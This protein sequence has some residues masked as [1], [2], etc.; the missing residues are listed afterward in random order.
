MGI[1]PSTIKE[2]E[3]K[4]QYLTPM[5][6][7]RTDEENRL[8]A[9]LHERM[10]EKY[11]IRIWKSTLGLMNS[12]QYVDEWKDPNYEPVD[13]KTMNIHDAFIEINK[14]K[15]LKKMTY[16]II[17]DAENVMDDKQA[18]RR[19]LDFAGQV[20]RH[21]DLLKC[22]VFV[23]HTVQVPPKLNPFVEV[24][25]L[26][27]PDEEEVALIIKDIVAGNDQV[28]IDKE[29]DPYIKYVEAK[30]KSKKD[31]KPV[32]PPD[33]IKAFM[34]LTFFQTQFLCFSSYGEFGRIEPDRVKE[35]KKAAVNKTDLISLM[36]TGLTF[37]DVGG[38]G[39]LKTWLR[40]KRHVFTPAG[41]EYGL[42]N[43]KGMLM[44]GLPG[45]GKTLTAKATAHEFGLPLI[46]FEPS[47]VF[48]GTVGSSEA[49]MMKAT[50]IIEQLS[51][52]VLFI[53]EIEK[54]LAGSQSSTFSD[55]GTTSRV[56]GLFLQWLQEHDKQVF[57]IAT[58][59]MIQ[60]LPPELLSRFDEIFFVELPDEA[61]RKAILDIHLRKYGRDPKAL[62]IDLDH[63]ASDEVSKDLVG[64][65]I[66]QAVKEAL[67]DSFEEVQAGKAKGLT[68]KHLEAVL[69]RK[70]P[71]V[72][73]M[74]EQLAYLSHWVGYDEKT[75]EGIRARYAGGNTKRHKA[76]IDTTEA[77]ENVT[78]VDF[79]K[80]KKDEGDDKK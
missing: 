14:D 69:K 28:S 18:V 3:Q 19:I 7:I 80:A 5:L 64:R 53:D 79:A 40:A 78:K 77:P 30:G 41:R 12:K 56:I 63:L 11:Q 42:P 70:I 37:D 38:L 50:N 59:N 8:I 25:S 54:G 16:Y 47:K 23:S 39:N 20:E 15:P 44:V 2:I 9:G 6:W 51:P 35:Y 55:G 61:S 29:I 57:T 45:A 10:N 17:L 4:L 76:V 34:G 72:K 32:E 27:L 1:K 43:L 33:T 71:V 31:L 49:N 60:H 66:D 36:E 62:N 68:T 75:G 65:E 52:C 67:F 26:A 21:T 74:E 58:A 48:S 22:L 73:T 24:V 13:R 46:H